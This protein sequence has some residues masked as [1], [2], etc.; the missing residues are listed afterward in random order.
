VVDETGRLDL[1]E[2]YAKRLGGVPPNVSNLAILKNPALPEAAV[3]KVGLNPQPAGEPQV[4][5]TAPDSAQ[6]KKPETPQESRVNEGSVEIDFDRLGRLGYVLPD[7]DANARLVKQFQAIKRPLIQKAFRAGQ[8]EARNN[9]SVVVTSAKPGEG[10][11]F[12]AINLAMSIASERDLKVMLLDGDLYNQGL[13]DM[14]GIKVGMGLTDLLLDDHLDV[15]KVLLATNVPNLAFLPAGR[16]HPKCT[17]LLS[18]QRMIQLMGEMTARYTNRIIVVN[19]PPI[20]ATTEAV[21]LA[22]HAGQVVMVVEQDRTGWRY[23]ERSLALLSNG[24]D[25]GF[26]L[27]KVRPLRDENFGDTYR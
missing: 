24:P 11:S 23:V 8:A 17:E 18:S 21:A 1:V 26:V 22:S 15:S 7:G 9:N 14:L 2:R 19:A 3:S 13:P 12:V 4:Q 20:L 6:Q 5:N 27:N 16:E 25:I 10:K